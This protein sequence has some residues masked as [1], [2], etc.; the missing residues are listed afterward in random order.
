M[1]RYAKWLKEGLEDR[2]YSVETW[3]AEPKYYNMVNHSFLKK[4]MGY[5]DQYVIFPRQVRK[6]LKQNIEKDD[7][8]FVFTD[9]ALGP[10]VP[11]VANKKH[12]IHCHDFLA[13][14]SALGYIP[15]NPVSFTGKVYQS[16]IRKGYKKG[17]NFICISEKTKEDLLDFL[18]PNKPN[19]VSVVYNGLNQNFLPLN[20][21]DC[22]VSLGNELKVNLAKGYI[23]HVGGNQWYKNRLGVVQ[24]YNEWRKTKINE[25]PLILV[26]KSPSISLRAAY[27]D[28]PYK[29]DIHFVI[30]VSDMLLKQTYAGA[31]VFLF[32]SLAE[33]FGW[34]IA[35][36]MA[37][38]V[39]VITTNE[40]PMTEVGGSIANYIPRK[41]MGDFSEYLQLGAKAIDDIL[42]MTDEERLELK[43]KSIL[44]SQKFDSNNTIDQILTIYK[45]VL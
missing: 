1:P 20:I 15:E 38:G 23:L 25:L 32:P 2:G 42:K 28:S 45:D 13:Q 24:L 37:S 18:K 29:H 14:K 10:W 30:D 39:P 44:Q 5:I 27:E 19:S 9:H 35:E 43:K 36:A 12:I 8:L 16:F 40:K 17:R 26:G 7:V 3:T 4:W 34:P 21:Q 31:S 11:L 41:K 22:R 33:G 6:R